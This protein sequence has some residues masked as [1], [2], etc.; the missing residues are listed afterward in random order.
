MNDD[1]GTRGSK[2]KTKHV[3]KPPTPPK[4]TTTPTNRGKRRSETYDEEELGSAQTGDARRGAW[5]GE[6]RRCATRDDMRLGGA[7]IG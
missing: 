7:W 4:H 6:D 2:R 3:S 5:I 1:Q